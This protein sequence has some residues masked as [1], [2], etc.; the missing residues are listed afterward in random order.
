[1][2]RFLHITDLHVSAPETDDPGRQ[3][4]TVASL[5]R[6]LDIAT[7]LDPRPDFIVASGDLTN[8]GDRASYDLVAARFAA[9]DIPVAM[10]LGNHDRRDGWH[11]AFPDHPAAPDGPVDHDMVQ[12]GVHII[13]LDSSVPG[14]VA[15]ALDAA[16]LERAQD[17][18]ARHPDL[19]K[20]IAVH[21]P[22]RIDPDEPLPWA[23]LDADST[24]KLAALL[25]GHNVL[26]ILS[27]HIHLNRV[28]LWNGIPLVVTMGQQSTVDLTRTD[29]MAVVEGTGFAICDLLPGGPR[30][31]FA[32]LETGRLI[33]EIPVERLRAFS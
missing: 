21:H 16:Q 30:I 5:D 28:A 12:A 19:P 32:P 11:A 27:G 24:E 8:I 31:T 6:L 4:D 23:T 10:T 25:K 29:A 3:T 9:L 33:K 20:L 7:R 15:G 22:P 26:A 18:L 1:M 14:K 17:M 13:A 2:T